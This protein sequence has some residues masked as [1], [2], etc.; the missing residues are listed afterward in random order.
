M[1]DSRQPCELNGHRLGG[2]TAPCWARRYPGTE[3]SLQIV[4]GKRAI[5]AGESA[6]NLRMPMFMCRWPNGDLSFLSA[7]NKED[8]VV[9]LD[10]FDNAELAD[11][12]QIRDFMVDFRLTDD[13]ELELQSFGE[14]C[15]GEIWDRAYPHLAEAMAKARTNAAGEFTAAGKKSIK[16]AVRAERQRLVGKKTLTLADTELG[17]SLQKQLGAPA[18]LINR[19]VKEVATE[20]LKKSP[21]SGRKQ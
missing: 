9:M 18:A 21:I 14:D 12:R 7:R 10:E 8:A 2:T 19:R 15:Q 4:S 17:R 6:Y 13:G 16:D 11:L 5:L 3:L 1:T 20:V